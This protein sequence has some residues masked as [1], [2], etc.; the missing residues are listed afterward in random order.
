LVRSLQQEEARLKK[1]EVVPFSHVP[2][3][4]LERS[5]AIEHGDVR[6]QAWDDGS[7]MAQARGDVT[8]KGR[9]GHGST[10]GAPLTIENIDD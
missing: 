4:V 5:A 9:S 8:L 1:G 2:A 3:E 10:D 7:K 6:S